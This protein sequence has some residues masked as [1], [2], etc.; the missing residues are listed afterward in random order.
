VRK[1]PEAEQVPFLRKLVEDN[2][3]AIVEHEDDVRV[4]CDVM[5][6]RVVFSIFVAPTDVGLALG[7][8]GANV[9][10]IRRLTWT[11][12]KKTS[13]KCD[14]DV[15]TNGFSSHPSRDR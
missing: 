11:A 10:A 9:D 8:D 12:C 4:E 1:K 13:Y 15:I 14:I 7:N 5:P 2:V 3:R 6:A